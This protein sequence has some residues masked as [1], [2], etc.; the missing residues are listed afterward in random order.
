MEGLITVTSLDSGAK[1][2]VN[3][4][5]ASEVTQIGTN[6]SMIRWSNGIDVPARVVESI[7]QI[8]SLCN[9]K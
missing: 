6:N 9:G 3:M 7:D 8:Y 5:A 1:Q 4:S 2:L